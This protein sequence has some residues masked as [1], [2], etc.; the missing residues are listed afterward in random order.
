MGV[1]PAPGFLV[2]EWEGVG[3]KTTGRSVVHEGLF[4]VQHEADRVQRVLGY[5]VP[6]EPQPSA[7]E[8]EG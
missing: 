6:R 4:L 8:G 5:V 7:E 1:H 3:V 2:V